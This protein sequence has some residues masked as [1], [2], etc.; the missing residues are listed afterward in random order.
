[1]YAE[2]SSPVLPFKPGVGA[3]HLGSGSRR[4]TSSM[5]SLAKKGVQ[6]QSQLHE[7]L[8]QITEISKGMNSFPL[9]QLSSGC[10]VT[11]SYFLSSFII[12]QYALSST[13]L[14]FLEQ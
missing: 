4:T 2:R 5:S 1:M 9:R 12:L 10:G 8:P 13:T 11:G 14:T 6:G 7:T 3:Q